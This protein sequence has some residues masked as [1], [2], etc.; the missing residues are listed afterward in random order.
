[1]RPVE[2]VAQQELTAAAGGLSCG[3]A[4]GV[5]EQAFEHRDGGVKRAVGGTAVGLAVPA[6][7]AELLPEHKVEEGRGALV[8]GKVG[9]GYRQHH[10]GDA[11]LALLAG[12]PQ[13]D[14]PVGGQSGVQQQCRGA[15]HR[16]VSRG[17]S[18]AAQQE[19]G[20]RG[21]GPLGG[22]EAASPGARRVLQSQQPRSPTLPSYPVALPRHALL[23]PAEQGRPG[24]PANRG[25]SLQ[26]PVDHR[27]GHLAAEATHRRRAG[28]PRAPARRS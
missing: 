7:V 9:S 16:R 14:A 18:H 3:T 28:G 8:P 13:V 26:Q 23:V 20:V 24:L 5:V 2:A 11:G 4:A 19:T 21:R 12:A 6:A 17:Q 10:A 1:M 27:F 15:P 22:V 25:I